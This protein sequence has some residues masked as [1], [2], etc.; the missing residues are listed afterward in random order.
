MQSIGH[1]PRVKTSERQCIEY[2]IYL[3][4]CFLLLLKK[5]ISSTTKMITTKIQMMAINRDA[6]DRLLN[7][8]A[9]LLRVGTAVSVG[10]VGIVVVVAFLFPSLQLMLISI[11]V[12]VVYS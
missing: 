3:C 8:S 6:A 9:L 7:S 1:I 10:G 11:E 5:M 4:A 2:F 12:E